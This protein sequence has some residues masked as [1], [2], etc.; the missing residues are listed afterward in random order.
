ML[1]KSLLFSILAS[2]A[3]GDSTVTS[4]YI[5]G[6]DEQPLAASIVGN[7]ATATTYSINCP[8]GTDATDCGMGSG[9]TLI[10]AGHSTTYVWDGR[11]EFWLTAKCSV[12]GDTAV[13]T[14]S[15]GGP[16]ANFP[17]TSTETSE[18]AYIPITITAGSFTNASSPGSAEPTSTETSSENE[19]A[20]SP[21]PTDSS[22]QASETSSGS[23]SQT[24]TGAETDPTGAAVKVK[25]AVGMVVGCV[26][27]ALMGAAM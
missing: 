7:D 23:V 6:A 1:L 5:Y 22:T 17:G 18:V 8:P 12:G 21:T 27:V 9:L 26:A 2:V 19:A 16:D 11:P 10:A 15:A 3:C 4:M 24:E 25:G 13:C 20:A 14:E